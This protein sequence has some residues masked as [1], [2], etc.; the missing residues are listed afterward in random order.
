MSKPALVTDAVTAKTPRVLPSLAAIKATS[1][2]DNITVSM[3]GGKLT[4]TIDTTPETVDAAP[5]SK[6]GK[7]RL[8]SNSGGWMRLP[9]TNFKM[10][11]CLGVPNS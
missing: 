5:P 3:E 8:I 1:V 6:S 11:L 2:G 4:I 7:L 9:G 10:N